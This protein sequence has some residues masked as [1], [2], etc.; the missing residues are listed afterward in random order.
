MVS[1]EL[2]V[3]DVRKAYDADHDMAAPGVDE[4]LSQQWTLRQSL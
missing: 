2:A 1:E 3:S 4:A